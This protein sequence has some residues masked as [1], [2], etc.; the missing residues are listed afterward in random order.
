MPKRF[1]DQQTA[2]LRNVAETL[3]RHKEFNQREIRCDLPDEKPAFIASV[4][5]QLEREGHISEAE[6]G[7]FCWNCERHDF[8]LDAWLKREKAGPKLTETP[9][10]DRPRERL[11]THGPASLRTAELL[12]ILIRVGRRGESALVAGEKIASHYA[13]QMDRLIEA[14]RGDLSLLSA[15]VGPSAYCQIMA[16]IE[17][18]R[19]IAQGQQDRQ[20]RLQRITDSATALAYCREQF[21]RLADDAAKEEFHI[22]CLDTRNQVIGTHRISVGIV[23]RS[24]VHPREVFRPAIKE[25]AKSIILVHNHPSGD[26]TPSDEDFT[27]TSR[28]EEAGK[29]VGIQILDHIIVAR[30][31]ATSIREIRGT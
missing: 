2:R 13:E 21:A 12:A 30:N 17:L 4:V 3:L 16:G 25:A 29:T 22:V 27:V 11:L 7:I 28:L 8:P 9:E 5:R 6:K 19:R 31:G 14:G 18:G 26:A 15:A 1:D 23:D 20:K 24:L 10:A